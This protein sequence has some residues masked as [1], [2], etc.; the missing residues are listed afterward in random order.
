LCRRKSLI[1]NGYR[2]YRVENATHTVKGTGLGLHLV[3][4][5]IE[6]HHQG[7]V[8]VKSKP[9]EGSTFGFWL[10]LDEADVKDVS[11]KDLKDK[12]CNENKGTYSQYKIEKIEDYNKKSEFDA[13]YIGQ[14]EPLKQAIPKE[15]ELEAPMNLVFEEI[16]SANANNPIRPTT[17]IHEATKEDEWEIT[18]EVR[19]N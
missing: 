14:T 12:T 8:F 3:K 4:I 11:L 18:F 7:Q 1:E 17:L 9:N 10:P 16:N 13:K 6:K 5:A 2:F 15:D 19:D